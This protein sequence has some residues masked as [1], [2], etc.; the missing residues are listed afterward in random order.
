MN[1]GLAKYNNLNLGGMNP[2]WQ[3]GGASASDDNSATVGYIPESRTDA[4]T[5]LV[6]KSARPGVRQVMA[7]RAARR[8]MMARLSG[9][10]EGMRSL[11]CDDGEV[12]FIGADGVS[13]MCGTPDEAAAAAQ[14]AAA[15]GAAIVDDG[16]DDDIDTAAD[17]GQAW[18]PSAVADVMALNGLGAIES[19]SP[20]ERRL[21]QAIVGEDTLSDTQLSHLMHSGSGMP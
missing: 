15:A 2:I 5:S 11:K 13:V 16:S 1:P 7:K 9:R 21:Q 17:C 19:D 10:R 18:D 14:A 8:A 6:R 20:G 12:Q 4:Y 3:R